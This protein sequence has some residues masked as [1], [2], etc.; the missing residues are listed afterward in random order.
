MPVKVYTA[1]TCPWCKQAKAFLTQRRVPFEEVDVTK[2]RQLVEEL[3]S[4]SGQIGVPVIMDGAAVII[5]FDKPALE[6]LAARRAS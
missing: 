1:P 2:D 3:L 6:N 5:G 4:I